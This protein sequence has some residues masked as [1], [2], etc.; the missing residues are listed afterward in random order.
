ME[1]NNNDTQYDSNKLNEGLSIDSLE[2]KLAEL[3][4]NGQQ[5]GAV[6]GTVAAAGQSIDLLD[7]SPKPANLDDLLS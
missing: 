3:K 7:M 6:S 2:A 5:T 1:F 4:K